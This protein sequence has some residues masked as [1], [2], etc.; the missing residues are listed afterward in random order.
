MDETDDIDYEAFGKFLTQQ[1]ELRGMSREEVAHSTKIPLSVIH[2]LETGQVEKLPARIFVVNYIR[3]YAKVIG[4]NADE[5]VL[6]YEEVDATVKTVP[7][8]AALERQRQK[9]ALLRL[10]VGG[11]LVA[12][13]LYA[14]LVLTGQLTPPWG[15]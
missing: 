4:L 8:P 3:A 6:R 14:F 5:A 1:R 15:K 13:A 7:P 9:G 2:S 10:V 12:F 11:A